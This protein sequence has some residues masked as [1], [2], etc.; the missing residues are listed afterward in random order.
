L[1]IIIMFGTDVPRRCSAIINGGGGYA[2]FV[3]IATMCRW[4]CE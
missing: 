2:S 4:C 1:L 3:G